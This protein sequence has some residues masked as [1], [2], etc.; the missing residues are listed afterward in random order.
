MICWGFFGGGGGN[1]FY[2][3]VLVLGTDKNYIQKLEMY[4]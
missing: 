2:M 4:G 3:F 1:A